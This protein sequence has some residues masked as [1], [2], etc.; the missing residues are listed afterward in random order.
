MY[1]NM[2]IYPAEGDMPE[3]ISSTRK[4]LTRHVA[5]FREEGVESEPVIFGDR[6]RPEAALLPYETFEL[7]LNAAED[8]VIAERIR[9]RSAADAGGRTSLDDVARELGV[10]LDA[11]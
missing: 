1:M 3:T 5:R 10:D 4:Q 8:I 7:L 6:R 9:E 11:L 2:Y